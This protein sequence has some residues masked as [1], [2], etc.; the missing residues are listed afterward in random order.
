MGWSDSFADYPA[1]AGW[2]LKHRLV[3]RSA[4]GSVVELQ[5]SVEGTAF[6][7]ALTAAATASMSAGAWTCTSWVEKGADVHTVGSAQLLV[8]PDPRTQAAGFDGRSAARKALDDA[9][10]AYHAFDPSRRRYKIGEREMEFN[11]AGEI[12]KKIQQLE[13]DVL[14]EEIAAGRSVPTPRRIYSRL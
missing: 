9:R 3:P 2:A 12:L 6:R 11:S 13:R 1:D 14:A 10:A 7:T 4:S 5:A 8:Q